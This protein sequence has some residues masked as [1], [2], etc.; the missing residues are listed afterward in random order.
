MRIR[1][2]RWSFGVAFAAALMLMLQSLT[3]AWATGTNPNPQTDI[4]GNVL[5]VTSGA[6]HGAPD[7]GGHTKSSECCLA[8]CSMFS[9]AAA[10]SNAV[11]LDAPYRLLWL[12]PSLAT[13]VVLVASPYR[14]GNPRA[15]PPTV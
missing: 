15:P 9:P 10:P 5:C 2:S 1:R 4:F 6:E 12:A 7:T 3:G 14:P 11:I 13:D 8:G